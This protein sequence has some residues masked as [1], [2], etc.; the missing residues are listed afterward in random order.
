[1]HLISRKK[2]WTVS[3]LAW[4]TYGMLATALA[5]VFFQE[6]GVERPLLGIA[7]PTMLSMWL[8]ALYTPFI[9]RASRRFPLW[10]EMLARSVP[11][12][13]GL[14]IALPVVDAALQRTM[15]PLFDV[16]PSPIVV[17]YLLY[18]D[19]TFFAYVAIV[20]F[21]HAAELSGRLRKEAVEKVR[22]ETELARAELLALKMQIQPHFLFNTLHAISE[23][24]HEDAEKADRMITRLGDLLRLT[25]E[26]SGTQEVAL[27][28]ELDL[29]RAYLAIQRVRFSDRLRVH[30]QIAPDTLEARVPNF[31]LQP[32][33]EN[34]IR[35]GLSQRKR[36]GR[37]EIEAR[38]EGSWL[39]IEVR[40]N[41][42]GLGG[43]DPTRE[44]LGLRNTRAR[45]RQLYG[46]DQSF[47]L[48]PA[49]GGGTRASFRLPFHKGTRSTPPTEPEA[50]AED[51]R[52]HEV[53]S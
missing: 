52:L 18:W 23:I 51:P 3:F 45:L 13:L 21:T 50:H 27:E 25:M 24:V 29:L 19:V 4:S 38:R 36:N 17:Q 30:Y 43:G 48:E 49:Q 6:R 1:M 22:L 12:H 31:L 16:E 46:H 14:V 10:R 15:A 42:S 35:H 11:V 26:S 34:A 32:V 28:Q 47:V 37:I 41:G 40:D 5:Y 9:Y 44:G 33:V 20:G 2:L 39:S 7:G 8:W 53:L